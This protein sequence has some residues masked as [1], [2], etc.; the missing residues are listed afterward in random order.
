VTLL[1]ALATAV[2]FGAGTFMLMRR[3][4][5]RDVAGMILVANAVNLFL[6][7][8]G[9]RRGRAPIHPLDGSAP[10]S[11]PL[12]QAMTLTA[13]V[14]GFGIVALLLG[15]VYG[16]WVAHGT[17]DQNDLLEAEAREHRAPGRRDEAA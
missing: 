11:D 9:L 8:A 6:M 7:A 2:L 5:I 10:V 3:D 13:I 16:V 12:V 15:L 1:L 17:V 14:I 4:L